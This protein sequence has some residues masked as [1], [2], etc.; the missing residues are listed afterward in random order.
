MA[1]Y[2]KNGALS[3]PFVSNLINWPFLRSYFGFWDALCGRCLCG[4]VA[5][6]ESWLFVEVRL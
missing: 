3:T 1:F 2:N 4:V 6:I 5:V